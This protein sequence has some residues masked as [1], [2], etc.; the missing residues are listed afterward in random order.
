MENYSELNQ[1]NMQLSIPDCF[2]QL[3]LKCRLLSFLILPFRNTNFVEL[4]LV[5]TE[6]IGYQFIFVFYQNVYT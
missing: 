2:S 4:I 1:S 5:K 3:V 6:I